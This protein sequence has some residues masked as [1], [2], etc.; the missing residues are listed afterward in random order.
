[1]SRRGLKMFSLH[2]K[3]DLLH[4]KIHSQPLEMYLQEREICLPALQIYPQDP[5]IYL[6]C[7]EID[8]LHLGIDSRCMPNISRHR[9]N[10]SPA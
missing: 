6:P 5:G 7:L 1:M 4:H 10:I 8:L 3:I 2:Q 9:R